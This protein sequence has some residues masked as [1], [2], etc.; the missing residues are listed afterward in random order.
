MICTVKLCHCVLVA[1]CSGSSQR[2]S[3]YQ[4]IYIA[5]L[6]SSLKV[7]QCGSL[8]KTLLDITLSVRMKKNHQRPLSLLCRPAPPQLFWSGF[9]KLFRCKIVLAT[10]CYK[11]SHFH[12]AFKSSRHGDEE[13]EQTVQGSTYDSQKP[14]L[15]P[16]SLLI[17][18]HE[19]V[20]LVE[21][22]CDSA[23]PTWIFI[24]LI[25]L[26]SELTQFRFSKQ[27]F[28]WN[29]TSIYFIY[30]PCCGFLWRCYYIYSRPW[31]L[32]CLEY[33]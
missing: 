22:N 8:R 7:Y 17:Q 27:N 26:W 23:S 5:D 33:F 25:S 11:N 15:F 24:G 1:V 9:L 4:C 32:P 13:W 30:A 18:P 12:F 16:L 20:L 28:L 10:R 19:F 3:S 31:I 14:D 6:N 21:T 2:F 29:S